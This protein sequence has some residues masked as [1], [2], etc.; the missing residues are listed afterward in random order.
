[1]EYSG[2]LVSWASGAA[3]YPTMYRMLSI[4]QC[5]KQTSSQGITSGEVKK[6]YPRIFI[7]LLSTIH[8]ELIIII[9]YI[10]YYVFRSAFYLE[11]IFI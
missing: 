8:L 6:R 4:L 9:L 11:L 7:I 5:T 1:M 10:V 2:H 3:K